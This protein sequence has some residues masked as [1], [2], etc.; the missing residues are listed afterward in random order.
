[1]DGDISCCAS[2][3]AD[4]CKDIAQ[5]ELVSSVLSAE[6][7]L[8]MRPLTRLTTLVIQWYEPDPDFFAVLASPLPGEDAWLCPNL[9]TIVVDGIARDMKNI[10]LLARVLRNRRTASIEGQPGAP[11][12]ITA[13]E[14]RN[15]CE[16]DPVSRLI[17]AAEL[18]DAAVPS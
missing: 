7:A 17:L 16:I 3:I 11:A 13:V 18:D 4:T 9:R 15:H 6:S 10:P 5:L 14:Y 1:M 2:F 8:A 12:R